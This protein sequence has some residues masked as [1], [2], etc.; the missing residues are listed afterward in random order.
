MSSAAVVIGALKIKRS[1]ESFCSFCRKFHASQLQWAE[2]AKLDLTDG[3][4]KI[5][6]YRD[7]AIYLCRPT[8]FQIDSVLDFVSASLQ[9]EALS[10][11]SYFFLQELT[12]F[13]KD[14]KPHMT[15]LPPSPG[16]LLLFH[17]KVYG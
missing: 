6:L 3:H 17:I 10:R 1:H 7:T 16:S 11:G 4:S 13:I 15:G 5:F 2:S 8:F 9:D 12:P 14:A